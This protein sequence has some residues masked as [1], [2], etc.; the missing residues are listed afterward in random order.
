[1]VV[2]NSHFANPARVWSLLFFLCSR[3]MSASAAYDVKGS[4]AFDQRGEEV[5]LSPI[6]GVF[7]KLSGSKTSF[8]FKTTGM[9]TRANTAIFKREN[10]IVPKV[11]NYRNMEALSN[12]IR[13]VAQPEQGLLTTGA[14][15]VELNA[16]AAFFSIA[17]SEDADVDREGAKKGA[18][19]KTRP[20]PE[21]SST[22]LVCMEDP[23]IRVLSTAT[24]GWRPNCDILVPGLD[25]KGR[26]NPKFTL[27]NWRETMP[28][29]FEDAPPEI[30]VLNRDWS[31][32]VTDWYY[33]MKE[34]RQ[35]M[36]GPYFQEMNLKGLLVAFWEPRGNRRF[37]IVEDEQ[38]RSKT[39]QRIS[40]YS[41]RTNRYRS[42]I[43]NFLNTSQA[44][45]EEAGVYCTSERIQCGPKIDFVIV[46]RGKTEKSLRVFK[47]VI[48]SN[49]LGKDSDEMF[50]VDSK[51]GAVDR[52]T[53]AVHFSAELQPIPT[54]TNASD[55]DITRILN[56]KFMGS[57]VSVT[58]KD[59]SERK[60]LRPHVGFSARMAAFC[61]G[62]AAALLDKGKGG[63]PAILVSPRLPTLMR[64]ASDLNFGPIKVATTSDLRGA[65]FA[66]TSENKTPRETNLPIK[67]IIRQD[68]LIVFNLDWGERIVSH[69]KPNSIQPDEIVYSNLSGDLKS[70][71]TALVNEWKVDTSSTA[72]NSNASLKASSVV[73]VNVPG[74]RG[75]LQLSFDSTGQPRYRNMPVKTVLGECIR[76]MASQISALFEVKTDNGSLQRAGIYPIQHDQSACLVIVKGS[77]LAK[78][79]DFDN[80]AIRAY[81]KGRKLKRDPQRGE[82]RGE[83][84]RDTDTSKSASEFLALF[85]PILG[86]KDPSFSF[87]ER[88]LE[89]LH[90]MLKNTSDKDTRAR[91]RLSIAI[92][93]VTR[94]LRRFQG[95]MSW[96]EAQDAIDERL[97]I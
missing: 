33:D 92:D 67:E 16:V 71:G 96:A 47:E 15:V 35:F 82:Q 51:N 26:R 49:S 93:Y 72:L 10:A 39:Q 81:E 34:I 85:D 60:G 69:L 28:D 9:D 61:C 54:V 79:Y 27:G 74:M 4:A 30:F 50:K 19:R 14:P 63:K 64:A 23:S 43:S 40:K 57:D 32:S 31:S 46:Y 80:L 94:H 59:I 29:E 91:I 7:A 21:F 66:Y 13:T 3:Q 52:M 88:T 12:L 42:F 75:D 20:R 77:R 90:E 73:V 38:T 8:G 58:V 45:R 5:L 84:K 44:E 25:A 48:G 65:E 83:L 97:F 62:F 6:D 17:W 24:S 87:D 18:E 78:T 70:I 55:A 95:T 68:G 76:L 22:A 53:G 41:D 56:R 11:A 37:P 36:T 86:S 89:G 2:Y 1:M